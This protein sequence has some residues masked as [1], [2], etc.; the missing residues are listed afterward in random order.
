MEIYRK[1]PEVIIPNPPD[2]LTPEYD[3]CRTAQ[4]LRLQ[5]FEEGHTA[6]VL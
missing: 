2:R 3:G 4:S 6:H 5:T 1:K